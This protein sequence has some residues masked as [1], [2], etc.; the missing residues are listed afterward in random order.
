MKKLLLFRRLFLDT[1]NTLKTSSLIRC[2]DCGKHFSVWLRFDFE[3]WE[4]FFCNED[5]YEH[6]RFPEKL[7]PV[8][9]GCPSIPVRI[10]HSSF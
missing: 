6:F 10:F 2:V 1:K 3:G 7:G 9:V 5:C 8:T 4:N